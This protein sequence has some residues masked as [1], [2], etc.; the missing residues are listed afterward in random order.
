MADNSDTNTPFNPEAPLVSVIM[1]L[2]AGAVPAHFSAAL[3][4]LEAQTLANWECLVC[5]DGPLPRPLL[6]MVEGRKAD[7]RYRLLSLN[8]PKG[9]AAAR[10]LGVREAR[11]RY[12][13]VWDSDDLSEPDRFARQAAF[14]E[15]NTHDLAGASLRLV[16]REGR[17]VETRALPCDAEA[18]RDA[19]WWRNPVAHSAVMVRAAWIKGHPYPEHMRYGEDYR[20]WITLA[21]EGG[22][23]A[24]LPDTLVSYRVAASPR[25]HGSRMHRAWSDLSNRCMALRLYPALVSLARFPLVLGLCIVPWLPAPLW[26]RFRALRDR[27]SGREKT[28]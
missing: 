22:R 10:N 6:E 5:A 28:G 4:S 16:D 20:L 2:H 1:A 19:L 11:G 25:A 27:L 26:R 8:A 7:R 3:E 13:A 17:F 12:I 15:E 18:I 24:N 21:L 23:M 9:P 14:L